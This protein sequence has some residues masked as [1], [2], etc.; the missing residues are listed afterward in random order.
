MSFLSK[1]SVYGLTAMYVLALNSPKKLTSKDISKEANIPFSFLEQILRM[2]KK[3]M[4][5]TSVK[6][7]KGG[8]TLARNSKEIRVLD[9][10]N[11][12]E[13]CISCV[14]VSN[15]NLLF[16]F[17]N[18]TKHKMDDIFMLSLEDLLK[19]NQNNLIFHI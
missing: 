1:K 10:L 8:Y 17:W 16:S 9:I 18:E 4:L 11:S 3:S 12:L 13:D 19:Q 5:I 15:D 14:E 6:G 2:L 7:S